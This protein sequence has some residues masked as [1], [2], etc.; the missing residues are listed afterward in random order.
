MNI[1]RKKENI[2]PHAPD[3]P[4]TIKVT[5]NI[6]E[7]RYMANTHAAPIQKIDAECYKDLHT[8]E[9]R[10]IVHHEH[11]SDDKASVSQ[12]LKRLRD[13]INTNLTNPECALWVTLTYAKN[14]TDPV[15]LYEDYRRFWQRFKHYL[16]KNDLP[17]AEYIITAEPQA[18]GAWHLHCLFFFPRKAPYIPNSD[19]EKIWKG[20]RKNE[21]GRG[22]TK[23]KSLRG[24]DNPGLYL[25]A[26]LGDMELTDAIAAGDASGMVQ[27]KDVKGENGQRMKKAIIKGARLH[28]YPAG[29]RL[30]RYS[31]NI[32]KPIISQCT[33]AEAQEIVGSA[34]LTF[35]RT[36]ELTDNGETI[37]IINY[38]QYNTA[39]KKS[40]GR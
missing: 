19:M 26:Y 35:E 31:R 13:L 25:T 30:Y 12:S 32:E 6:T 17:S 39:K 4:V 2:R 3:V 7:I 34:P 15:T 14:M 1:D 9:I 23:V 22:F 18:R 21:S 11:R 38:R 27:E 37:N 16:K 29:F 40:K 24:V 10:N 5:G 33:E 8:G 28:L 20:K 36:Y